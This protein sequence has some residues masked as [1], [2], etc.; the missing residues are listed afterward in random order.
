VEG[1]KFGEAVAI[2]VLREMKLTA[3]ER[4]RGYSLTTFAGTRVIV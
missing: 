1:L 2:E 3:N 4:F